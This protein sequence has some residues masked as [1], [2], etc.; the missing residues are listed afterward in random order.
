MWIVPPDH[1]LT[2]ARTISFIILCVQVEK[3]QRRLLVREPIL[4]G[5]SAIFLTRSTSGR[6]VK[7]PTK[8][9]TSPTCPI[10]SLVGWYSLWVDPCHH[11]G[12]ML[13]PTV[14]DRHGSL[15]KEQTNTVKSIIFVSSLFSLYTYCKPLNISLGLS[16]IASLSNV[17]SWRIEEPPKQYVITPPQHARVG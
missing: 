15:T 16:L 2:T 8:A 6:A 9:M 4:R 7:R 1:S 10:D 14:A 12:S 13:G 11:R 3:N 5:C 17:Q